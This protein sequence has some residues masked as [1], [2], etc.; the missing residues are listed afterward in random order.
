MALV[1]YKSDLMTTVGAYK[2]LSNTKSAA[3][4]TNL[5]SSINSKTEAVPFFLDL[6]KVLLGSDAIKKSCGEMVNN[7]FTTAEPKIKTSLTKQITQPNANQPLP[8]AFV[9]E[10]YNIPMKNIDV[11]G[12]YKTNP[13]SS[14]GD[15]LYNKQV[16]NFDTSMSN[17]ISANGSNITY[18]NMILNYNSTN[19]TVNIK[20]SNPSL[21]IGTILSSIVAGMIIID[22]KEFMTNVMNAIFGTITTNQNKTVNNVITEM[23]VNNLLQKSIGSEPLFINQSE[24]NNINTMA[25]QL[26]AGT[27]IVSLCCGVITTSLPLSGVTN[28]ISQISG[29]TSGFAISNTLQ[30]ALDSSLNNSGQ[31][32]LANQN[33][34]N[35]SDSYFTN[36]INTITLELTKSATSTPQIKVLKALLSGFQHGQPQTTDPVSDVKNNEVFINCMSKSSTS[37]INEFLFNEIKKALVDLIVPIGKR[38]AQ[39]KINNYITV[40]KSLVSI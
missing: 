9:S 36:I 15:L 22:T 16:P 35:V 33:N 39:E 28:T 21:T 11:Y 26:I 8:S 5:F 23:S 13:N 14:T 29:S 18:N 10:G 40:L 17:A 34:Q 12:K 4:T 27:N 38:I 24:L 31:A 19:D 32:A 3:N 6:L 20:P 7:I 30:N 25:Q 1:N 37:I 2:T